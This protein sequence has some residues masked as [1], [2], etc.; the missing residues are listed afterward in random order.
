VLTVVAAEKGIAAVTHY[1]DPVGIS[2]TLLCTAGVWGLALLLRR[3]R[4]AATNSPSPLEQQPRMAVGG[5]PLLARLPLFGFGLLVWLAAADIGVHLWYASL[6]SRLV[7]GPEWSV[8]FPTNNLSF[9]TSPIPEDIA[10][11][12]RFDEGKEGDWTEADGT[13]WKAYY[14]SWQP[15]RVTGYLAKRHTP[16]ECLPATGG[17][18]LSAPKLTLLNV[19]NI[20]LPIRS[21]EW[22]V[23]GKRV[24]VFQC[25]WEAGTRPESYV[26]HESTR[27]NLIRGI[28][29]G[30]GNKGQKVVEVSVFGYASLHAAESALHSE[31]DKL[32]TLNSAK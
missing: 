14:F 18:V 4:I 24:Y 10:S 30:R 22:D 16:E 26:E 27:Y 6:E 2:T 25:R 31:L 11:V 23:E 13:R 32:I 1:H 20:I 9:K 5:E 8:A 15:G 17:S 29:A 21:Y 12:L 19:K 28:W 3:R 7:S